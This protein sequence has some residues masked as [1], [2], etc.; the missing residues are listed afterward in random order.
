MIGVRRRDW[1]SLAFRCLDCGIGY[2]NAT[3]PEVRVRIVRHVDQA[4][5]GE[6]HDGLED[7]LAE[8]L[9]ERN[10][11]S[12]RNAFCSASSEDAVTWTVFRGL[13]VTGRLA[14]V[15]QT[16]T[17]EHTESRDVDLLLWGV[18]VAGP[19]GA[20]IR[21]KLIAV[22]DELGEASE[23][24]SEPDVILVTETHVV[25]IEAKTGS[26]NDVN[27][28]SNG[29]ATYLKDEA[30]FRVEAKRV[31]E[32]GFYELVRNWVIGNKLADKLGRDY[33]LV[34]LGPAGLALDVKRLAPLLGTTAH[35]TFSH[36]RWTQL[37]EEAEPLPQWLTDYVDKVGL[38]SM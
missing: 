6:V 1:E 27:G 26:R 37:L 18:P 22:S 11:P 30:L 38:R 25:F 10:R 12:K 20:A 14:R 29:W 5:P 7:A 9:N 36:L 24:R 32:A 19:T 33:L 23:S 2:S 28:R 4:V 15:A 3:N 31:Q 34:N 13:D 8:A 21:N 35:R 16:I 17:R